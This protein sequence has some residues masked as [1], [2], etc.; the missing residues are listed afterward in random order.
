MRPGDLIANT[1]RLGQRLGNGGAAEVFEAVHER[2]GERVAIKVLRRELMPFPVEIE[3]FRFEVSAARQAHHHGI[4]DIRDMGVTADGRPYLV[5]EL[6]RGSTLE[7]I[8]IPGQPL[9]VAL[10]CRIVCQIL[11]A[12]TAAHDAGIVH[13]DLKPAN[14]FVVRGGARTP[15]VKLLDFGI[16]RLS[17][18]RAERRRITAKGMVI[19]TPMYMSPEQVR[20]ATDLDGRSDLFSLGIVLYECVTGRLPFAEHSLPA[21]LRFL[22][23]GDPVPP[24]E[25]CPDL[26]RAIVDVIERALQKDPALR[27]QSAREMFR[28]LHPYVRDNFYTETPRI[29]AAA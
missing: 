20:G 6:L 21:L 25:L 7:A 28:D 26:P 11:A 4:V 10:S 3:R 29:R 13:R 14:I 12:L 23:D 17:G 22:L 8:L 9:D 24:A 18:Q 2:S 1:Y 5:M 19:G 16:A 15:Q 27:Y